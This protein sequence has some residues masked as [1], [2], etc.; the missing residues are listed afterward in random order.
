VEVVLLLREAVEV[1][2]LL[3]EGVLLLALLAAVVVKL[4]TELSELELMQGGSR[5]CQCWRSR[6]ESE[7][8]RAPG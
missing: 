4:A 3:V 8:A 7:V 6:V 2:F 1:V 5:C